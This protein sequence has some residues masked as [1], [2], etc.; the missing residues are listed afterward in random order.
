[1]KF[2]NAII[3]SF[4]LTTLA[5]ARVEL[6][7]V[8][9]SDQLHGSLVEMSSDGKAM[10]TIGTKQENQFSLPENV[11][12]LWTDTNGYEELPI[13]VG[14]QT[15]IR[16]LSYGSHIVH[17]SRGGDGFR[18]QRDTGLQYF[19]DLLGENLIPADTSSDGSV[20]VGTEKISGSFYPVLVTADVVEQPLGELKGAIHSVSAD[21]KAMAGGVEVVARQRNPFYINSIDVVTV[22]EEYTIGD[23]GLMHLSGDGHVLL[24]NVYDN[25]SVRR[26][27]LVDPY[28]E[29]TDIPDLWVHGFGT[30]E[31]TANAGYTANTY[32][33]GFSSFETLDISYSGDILVGRVVV[34]EHN[35]NAT[36]AA[37]LWLKE[38]GV[39]QLNNILSGLDVSIPD[40]FSL[41]DIIG[42]S[43]DGTILAGNGYDPEGNRIPWRITGMDWSRIRSPGF[44]LKGFSAIR[45]GLIELEEDIL[46]SHLLGFITAST[47]DYWLYSLNMG[48][49]FVQGNSR[50]GFWIWS[51]ELGWLW[52]SDDVYPFCYMQANDAWIFVLGSDLLFVHAS[53]QSVGHF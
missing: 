33:L 8:G 35:M 39:V 47:P 22:F 51:P 7:L 26:N 50:D 20:F 42:I 41:S 48:W 9:G 43:A 10:L 29:I 19:V 17:G 37:C 23:S 36:Y 12:Y 53:D 34:G 28:G 46:Y 32:S 27:L 14:Y 25:E 5:T 1:M 15:I 16:G 45:E 21:G 13:Q 2:N 18:W 4:C 3:F 49:I 52:T 38:L 11:I 31:Y 24:M 6:V 30:S 44:S 40:G